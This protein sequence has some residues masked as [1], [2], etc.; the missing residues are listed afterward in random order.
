VI[1]EVSGTIRL[2]QGPLTVKHPYVTI[3]GQT[4]PNPG[5]VIRGP[6]LLIDT[7]DVVVQHLRVRVGTLPHQPG[8][9]WLRNDATGV[10][11][12]H[13]SLSW[14]VW[15]S[16]NIGAYN[17]GHPTGEVTIMDSIISESLAC[18]GVNTEVPCDPSS[19]P[20]SGW[21]NSRAIGI[22]DGWRHEQPKVAL[23]RNI[24]A[25]N[26]DRHPEIPGRTQTFLVNNLIYNPSQAPLSSIYYEDILGLG[27]TYSVVQGN[28]LIP[29][30]TTPGHGAYVPLEYAEDGPVSL[31]RI[32]RTL[33][34]GSQIYMAGNYYE[35]HCGG[36][37]CLANPSAQW[38]LARDYAFDWAGVNA[39]ATTPPI[40]LANL[41]LS[42]ALP[43]TEVESY[44]KA[45]A[46]ARPLGRDAV[47]ARIINE[48]TSRSGHVPN[49]PAERAGAGTSSDGFPI[50]AE[51][52]RTLTVPSNPHQVVDSVGRT[53]IEEWLEGFARE[54]EPG[55]G[56]RP[57]APA[58]PT[59]VRVESYSSN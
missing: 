38:M 42:T 1:F 48:I 54:L 6:G 11:I 44:L 7:H 40:S 47:D 34:P 13:V 18:S 22:G 4:S 36:T 45:N 3:A 52:R 35:K 53:R 19:Y 59:N 29:G 25:H 26:N 8:G 28:V 24:T 20:G 32:D 16:L 2:V 31:V 10:V 49:T 50:V 23:I 56:Q 57:T 41:P 58:G 12:D 55:R 39:R 9:L 27:P 14:A 43:Y 21:S 46:G 15:T 33:S 51:N 5:I 17:A 30:P 37:A